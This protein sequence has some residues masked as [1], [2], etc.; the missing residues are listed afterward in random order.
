MEGRARIDL[1][2]PS[3]LQRVR[4][5]TAE[6]S[7]IDFYVKREDLIHTDISGNKWRKL[8]YNLDHVLASDTKGIIT[9]GGAFSNHI[10]ATA[11]A[12]HYYGISTVGIIRGEDDLDNPTLRQARVWGM[13]L[14][15]ISRAA[16]REKEK[17]E[18]VKAIRTGLPDHLLLPEGG[19]NQLA[20]LGTAEIVE[21]ANCQH[22]CQHL[23][24]S[25]GTG[26]TAAG[27][28]TALLPHQHLWVVSALK[29]DF[30]KGE[31]NR[32]LDTPSS[33]WTLLTKYHRGGYARVDSDLIDF[34][35][36]YYVET[37]IPLDPIYNG[38]SMMAL[39]D[40]IHTGQ[41]PPRSTV[42]YIHTGGRQGIAAHNYMAAKRGTRGINVE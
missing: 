7:Y 41:I 1:A 23:I 40:L 19:S 8:K 12:G 5:C 33:Q 17:A 39:A 11:A 15:F 35:H 28:I 13:A 29:G 30:L 38:K 6:A 21:E 2:L 36:A 27:M 18:I 25:A 31:I 10:H 42:A 4:W 16:Y 9:F 20:L 24:V 26:A 22:D 32:Y 37:G 14:H 34:I 3:P